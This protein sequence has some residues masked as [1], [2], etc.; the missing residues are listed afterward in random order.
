MFFLFLFSNQLHFCI[1]LLCLH[2][3]ME[4]GG[5]VRRGLTVIVMFDTCS[6]AC[7]RACYLWPD[8]QCRAERLYSFVEVGAQVEQNSE[9]S[10]QVGI[11]T[12]HVEQRCLLEELQHALQF[13]AAHAHTE[14]EMRVC[15]RPVIVLS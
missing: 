7:V 10:L 8:R 14:S 15:C 11:H 6:I 9:S 13:T 5:G 2:V 12:V 1:I 4:V 3:C